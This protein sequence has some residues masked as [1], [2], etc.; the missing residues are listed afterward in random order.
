MR[1]SRKLLEKKNK[2]RSKTI[3]PI[4]LFIPPIIGFIVSFKIPV[5]SYFRFLFALPFLYLLIGLFVLNKKKIFYLILTI[6]IVTSLIYVFNPQFHRENWKGLAKWLEQKNQNHSPIIIIDQISKPLDY[7]YPKK[8]EVIKLPLPN[9]AQIKTP[10]NQN[11]IFLIS[12]GIAIFD[13]ENNIR[14]ELKNQN[15]TIKQGQSFNKVGIEVWQRQTI[16]SSL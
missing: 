10:I 5:F 3:L 11:Q 14:Q 2:D 8:K 15:F 6:N 7:Y 4:L 13:P 12:Y 9:I 1:Y 16:E